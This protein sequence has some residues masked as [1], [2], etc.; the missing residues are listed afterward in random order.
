[1]DCAI[2]LHL[3]LM[4]LACCVALLFFCCVVFFSS[5][6]FTVHDSFG[7]YA[8]AAACV[9][10]PFFKVGNE[11]T[12][13]TIVIML[14]QYDLSK[15]LCLALLTKPATPFSWQNRQTKSTWPNWLTSSELNT[16]FHHK[17]MQCN[18]KIRKHT[19]HRCWNSS[20]WFLH[21]QKFH[22]K[23]QLSNVHFY[24]DHFSDF[25]INA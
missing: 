11:Q 9:W 3:W 15:L 16:C 8:G 13:G 25:R 5:L 22:S 18:V 23:L 1:M 4:G 20:I 10:V 14:L 17:I 24:W 12:S 19:R 6:V 21:W 7:R 2:C